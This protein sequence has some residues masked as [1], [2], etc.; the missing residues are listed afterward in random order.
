V[1]RIF[2]CQNGKKR[3]VAATEIDFERRKPRE[4][5]VEL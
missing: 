4:N 5:F 2:L 3:T 1:R